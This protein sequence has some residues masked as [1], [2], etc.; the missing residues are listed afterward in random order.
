MP[1]EAR[2]NN[3]LHRELP[4][5]AIVGASAAGTHFAA[6]IL[7]VQ[8]FHWHPLLANIA[9]FICA[10]QISYFGHRGWTFS[11]TDTAHRESLSRFFAVAVLGFAANE[12][13]YAMLL[14]IA[15]LPYWLSLALVQIVVAVMTFVLSKIWAFR[16]H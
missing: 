13:L 15:P 14:Q 5:F 12:G 4:R 11:A 16:Q 7:L 8:T 1:D 10:F 9:A 3:S 2:N 6:V